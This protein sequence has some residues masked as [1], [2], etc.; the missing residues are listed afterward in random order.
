MPS[1]SKVG[2]VVTV[3]FDLLMKLKTNYST[4]QE[5]KEFSKIKSAI[6]Q[7]NKLSKKENVLKTQINIL[8]A[9]TLIFCCIYLLEQA[10]QQELV[11]LFQYASPGNDSKI[12]TIATK[13]ALSVL[14]RK[15]LIL[16]TPGHY[17]LTKTGLVQFKSNSLKRNKSYSYNLKD[18][19]LLR[20]KIIN[21]QYRN[22]RFY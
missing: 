11:N 3:P 2:K 9:D 17:Q 13:S 20:V 7:T 14:I 22:K 5:S 6:N 19:D 18:M 21:S 15:N 10:Q 12:A 16:K 4:Y 8:D 1:N